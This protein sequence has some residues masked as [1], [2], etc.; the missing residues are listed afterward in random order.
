MKIAFL[1]S[2]LSLSAWSQELTLIKRLSRPGA[3]DEVSIS[4]NKGEW[5]YIKKSNL[6]D[7]VDSN[8]VGLFKIAKAT[9]ELLELKNRYRKILTTI[10]NAEE[11]LSA[12]GSHWNDLNPNISHQPHFL[13]QSYFVH[14]QSDLYP[15][16]ETLFKE[17]QNLKWN[18]HKGA[19]FS[20][21]D[22]Q[23]NYIDN[24]KVSRVE[25]LVNLV[26][27]QDEKFP[28][29]CSAKGIEGRVYL[30]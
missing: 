29:V 23:I 20:I 28:T 4:E 15:Q 10:N 7:S 1:L 8:D 18:L 16:L 2:I 17:L 25:K 21:K 9:P 24:G 26:N 27:C 5:K 19:Q 6:F 11:K 13:I 30:K 22:R 3:F 14:E 12:Q